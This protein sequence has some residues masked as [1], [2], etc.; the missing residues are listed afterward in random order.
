ME[1]LKNFTHKETWSRRG[2]DFLIEVV[3]WESMTEETYNRIKNE[4]GLDNGRYVWNIYCY[5][6]PKHRLFEGISGEG[7]CPVNVFHGGCTFEKWNTKLNGEVTSK[8][9][10]CDYNHYGDDGY[11]WMETPMQAITIFNDA[12]EIF[13]ELS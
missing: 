5:I 9:Y 1:I 4:I 7:D 13:E 6:Y 3:R 12:Q 10:G 8:Q 2:K 11:T